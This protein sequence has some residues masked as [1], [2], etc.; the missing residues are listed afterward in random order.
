MIQK[1]L[2]TI[3]L[4]SSIQKSMSPCH[5]RTRWN[6]NFGG[7]PVDKWQSAILMAFRSSTGMARLVVVIF[8]GVFGHL[9]LESSAHGGLLSSSQVGGLI[10]EVIWFVFPPCHCSGTRRRVFFGRSSRR[11]ECS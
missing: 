3:G 10:S 4:L 9:V 7:F 6:R 5:S 1:L 8:F 2:G 11:G